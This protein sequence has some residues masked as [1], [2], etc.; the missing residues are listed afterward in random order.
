MKKILSIT[1][2]VLLVLSLSAVALAAGPYTVTVIN[3]MDGSV[4]DTFEVA[5]GEDFVFTLQGSPPCDMGPIAEGEEGSGVTTDG[6]KITYSNVTLGG[7]NQ[8]PTAESV[9]I[10]EIAGDITVTIT[11]NPDEVDSEFP[12]FSLGIVEASAS[13]EPSGEASG[14][15]SGD[16]SM[17]AEGEIEITVDGK[18][19]IAKFAESD[20]GDM[21]TKGLTITFDGQEYTGGIDKGVYTAD[22]AAAQPI[23]EAV[24]AAREANGGI[25]PQA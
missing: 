13:G 24:Q 21:A 5:E 18:T 25:G 23:F 10:S 3:G 16:A 6:G 7:P 14:E 20:N 15:A 9:T 11:P 4:Y 8:Y 22:D 19:G 2:A 12:D 1:L 17:E